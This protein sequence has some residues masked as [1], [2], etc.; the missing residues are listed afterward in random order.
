MYNCIT[1][2]KDMEGNETVLRVGRA[3]SP[4]GR[5]GWGQTHY[6]LDHHVEDHA[7]ELLLQDSLP[8]PLGGTR[9]RYAKQFKVADESL[10][11]FQVIANWAPLNG[12]PDTAQFGVVTAYCSDP[13][14]NDNIIQYCPDIMPPF[15]VGSGQ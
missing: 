3:N 10:I 4:N 11:A 13:K 2:F 6:K 14:N 7:V 5:G 12:G 9:T 1:Q 15:N 8:Q